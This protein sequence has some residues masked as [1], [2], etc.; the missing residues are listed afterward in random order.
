MLTF[1]LGPL[2]DTV[3]PVDERIEQLERQRE[4]LILA[5]NDQ[6]EQL[7]EQHQREKADLAATEAKLRERL[8][9]LQ[10]ELDKAQGFDG[11]GDDIDGLRSQNEFLQ[12]QAEEF[13]DELERTLNTED[14]LSSENAALQ[15]KVVTL[16]NELDTIKSETPERFDRL[17]TGFGQERKEF[18]EVHEKIFDENEQLRKSLLKLNAK[19]KEFTSMI[20]TSDGN[21]SV[22]MSQ[23]GEFSIIY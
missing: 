3:L 13:A 10:Q 21:K 20:T 1:D 11:N 19:V 17:V 18:D 16:Q 14:E 2:E 6:I 23:I 5:K 8:K 4:E 7:K 22:D 15:E 9:E 12:R